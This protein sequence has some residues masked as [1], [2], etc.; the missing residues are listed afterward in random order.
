ML[1]KW[2]LD[3]KDAGRRMSD[4]MAWFGIESEED[5]F[6][7]TSRELESATHHNKCELVLKRPTSEKKAVKMRD[8]QTRDF[9][10]MIACKSRDPL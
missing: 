1:G 10:V 7:V 4:G 6:W 2:E 9:Y 8:E 5:G 3:G